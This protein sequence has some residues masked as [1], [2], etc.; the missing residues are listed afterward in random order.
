[1][2]DRL[3][4]Q[5]LFE[6]LLES[7]NVYFQPPESLQI[8]YPAIVYELNNIRSK[9]ADGGT[10]LFN[11]EYLVTV[12]DKDPDSSIVVKV[13]TLPMCRFDRHFES[14]NLNHYVFVLYF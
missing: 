11:S 13:L 12:I 8:K 4:L 10:Y 9:F 1:M 2:G 7:R 6:N 5:T 3:E 14:D